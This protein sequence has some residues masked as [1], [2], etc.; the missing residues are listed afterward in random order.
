MSPGQLVTFASAM[1]RFSP[2][3]TRAG[4]LS[5][6]LNLAAGSATGRSA[7]IWLWR[8]AGRT[9]PLIH[10]SVPV[11]GLDSH[12]KCDTELRGEGLDWCF[13]AEALSGC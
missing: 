4:P 5:D 2:A 9:V 6:G 7:V 1:M 11:M 13:E 10:V 12:F 8:S 3:Q